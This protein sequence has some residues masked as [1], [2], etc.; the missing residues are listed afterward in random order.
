MVEM[1]MEEITIMGA[2]V[3]ELY[4]YVKPESISKGW[5]FE[6]S[7]N[8]LSYVYEDFWI[9]PAQMGEGYVQAARY[10]RK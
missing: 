7:H 3:S 4:G 2:T 10:L 6:I 5:P 9:L 8:G 1:S